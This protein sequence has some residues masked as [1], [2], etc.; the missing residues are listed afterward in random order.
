VVEQ[1]SCKQTGN[2]Q[3]RVE[4]VLDKEE[5]S[6]YYLQIEYSIVATAYSLATIDL[7]AIA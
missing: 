6:G 3:L 2:A 5:S 4:H 7:V 1:R